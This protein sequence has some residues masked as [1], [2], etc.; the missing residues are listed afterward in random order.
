MFGLRLACVEDRISVF[1]RRLGIALVVLAK[2]AAT[3]GYVGRFRPH[4]R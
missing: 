4:N 2:N 3:D 1:L